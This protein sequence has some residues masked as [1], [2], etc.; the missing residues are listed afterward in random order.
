MA[1]SGRTVTAALGLHTQLLTIVDS[2]NYFVDLFNLIYLYNLFPS[3]LHLSPGVSCLLFPSI[4]RL[5]CMAVPGGSLVAWRGSGGGGL[6]NISM[7]EV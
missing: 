5:S 1:A 2:F 6:H 7:R 4:L 3:I